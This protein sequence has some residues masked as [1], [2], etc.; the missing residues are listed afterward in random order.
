MIA[1]TRRLA[2][3]GPI[4]ISLLGR[5]FLALLRIR[6]ALWVRPWNRV[7]APAVRT[8]TTESIRPVVHRLEWA[9]L[10]AS[11]FVPRATCLTRALALHRLLVHYG[12]RSSVQVGAR[13]ADGRFVAHAWVEHG[14]DSLLSNASEVTRYV[15]FFSWPPSQPDLP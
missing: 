3:L 15:R 14:T 13:R 9:V 1:T 10:A 2:S 12:Y 8:V 6:I 5:A 7:T 11:R 4:E